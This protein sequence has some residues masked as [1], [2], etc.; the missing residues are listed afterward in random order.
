[1]E[2]YWYIAKRFRDRDYTLDRLGG[3]CPDTPSLIFWL[4]R[5]V[6]GMR[7]ADTVQ[8]AAESSGQGPHERLEAAGVWS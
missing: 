3:A 1:M 8:L 5:N 2:V 4:R 7:R 6:N